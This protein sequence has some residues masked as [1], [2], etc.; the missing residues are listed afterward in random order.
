M[1]PHIRGPVLHVGLPWLILFG[2]LE[3]AGW[4]A[5]HLLLGM[6]RHP[7]TTTAL[8]ATY[9]AYRLWTTHPTTA[10]LTGIALAA[11]TIWSTTHPETFDTY[12][13][14]HLR[15]HWRRNGYRRRWARACTQA[16]FQQPT[17]QGPIPPQLVRVRS[18]GPHKD[19]LRARLDGRET[20]EDWQRQA[21]LIARA[22]KVHTVRVK[23]YRHD[24]VELTA[25]RADPLAEPIDPTDLGIITRNTVIDLLPDSIRDDFTDPAQE[26]AEA[27][28]G[29]LPAVSSPKDATN[30]LQAIPV[31]IRE[32]GQPLHLPI[33]YTHILIAGETGAGKGS[34]LWSLICGA[35][36]HIAT[37]H[38]RI[39]AIDPKGGM[40]LAA[41]APLYDEFRWGRDYG[42]DHPWQTDIAEL[43]ED[44]VDGLRARADRLRG[45][46]RKH[47]PT[48]EQPL[49]V[50]LIDELG[51]LTA[52]INDTDLRRRI[53]TALSLL[54]SQGRAVGIT[55]I[56]ATQDA[57]KENLAFRDLFP[58][59]VALRTAEATQ[60]DMILGRGAY[61]RGAHTH[62]IS[63]A[64]PGVAYVSIDGEPDPV[65]VRA[66]HITDQHIADTAAR[67]APPTRTETAA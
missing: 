29:N 61:D 25:Y 55:V 18:H 40:E 31:G 67:H 19:V 45:T 56:A 44:A 33:L 58:T 50:I 38:V 54:L 30:Y 66:P 9:A 11:A 53:H 14:N 47:Q 32:D 15:T 27:L 49:I 64:T 26:P 65:R 7:G 5:L 42:T 4:L 43:L 1:K 37:G 35:A 3:L 62:R 24:Q 48:P 6:K 13:G 8:T 51:A 60:A 39:F 28:S 22:L 12:I 59:R 46:T 21:H 52:Y 57:R 36:P 17:P 34:V 41:G 23:P 63:P 10:P 16:G 2:L 20:V